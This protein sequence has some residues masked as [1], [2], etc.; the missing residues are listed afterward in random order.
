MNIKINLMHR[1]I[2]PLV[3]TTFIIT[4]LTTSGKGQIFLGPPES[5]TWSGSEKW[6]TGAYGAAST[7]YDFNDPAHGVCAFVLS[8]TVAGTENQADWRCEFFSL[9]PAAGGARPL[10]FSFAYKLE[11]PV[12]AKNNIIVLLRFYDSTGAKFIG[13]R[14]VQVGAHTSD[15]A[16]TS[17][18]T[19]TMNGI[20]VPP[21]AR[22]IDIA[23]GANQNANEPWVSGVARF[24]DFSVTT[25][26]RSLLF[27]MGV[28]TAILLG[29]GALTVLLIQLWRRRAGRNPVAALDHP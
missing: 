13:Q 23:I 27:K 6:L 7:S 14:V 26:P 9:G 3:V 12:A 11:N 24:D 22:T 19:L 16:M 18:R 29:L 20:M 2:I 28:G 10:T 8:N 21:K 5:G 4:T 17:Y 15:S 25:V 1:C